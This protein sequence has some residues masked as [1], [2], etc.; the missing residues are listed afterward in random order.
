MKFHISIIRNEWPNSFFKWVKLQ[1]N[2]KNYADI[3]LKFNCNYAS[4]MIMIISSFILDKIGSCTSSVWTCLWRQWWIANAVYL[5]KIVGINLNNLILIFYYFFKC[6]SSWRLT[7]FHPVWLYL[8]LN[9]NGS[10]NT[11][12]LLE[13]NH[14]VSNKPWSLKIFD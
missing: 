11:V 14:T 2:K 5:Q 9:G 7:H 1:F 12:F 6:L 13:N 3:W 10:K 8:L 4:I